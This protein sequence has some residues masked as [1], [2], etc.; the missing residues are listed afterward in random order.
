MYV[1]TIHLLREPQL[2][3]VNGIVKEA[4]AAMLF[5]APKAPSFIDVTGQSATV[6]RINLLLEITTYYE[7]YF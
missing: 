5:L 3:C 2:N 4:A 6:Q 1:G 7:I